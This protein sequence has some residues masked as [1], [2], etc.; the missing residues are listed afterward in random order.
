MPTEYL[1]RASRAEL[2]KRA[3]AADV[4]V[5][6]TYRPRTLGGKKRKMEEEHEPMVNGVEWRALLRSF[7]LRVAV[8]TGAVEA[9]VSADQLSMVFTNHLLLAVVKCCPDGV[10]GFDQVLCQTA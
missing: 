8:E 1:G 2:V 9:L 10:H 5:A 7:V 4:Y 6:S 3:L